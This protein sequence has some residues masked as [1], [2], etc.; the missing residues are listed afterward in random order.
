MRVMQKIHFII[1]LLA[2]LNIGILLSVNTENIFAQNDTAENIDSGLITTA[3]ID[4]GLDNNTST[5]LTNNTSVI[6]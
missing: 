1:M 6:E 5:Q 4:E 2:T 3:E